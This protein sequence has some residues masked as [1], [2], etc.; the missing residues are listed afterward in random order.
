MINLSTPREGILLTC[1]FLKVNARNH[2]KVILSQ[3][4]TP[5]HPLT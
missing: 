4:I 3:V 5:H 1:E 2:V